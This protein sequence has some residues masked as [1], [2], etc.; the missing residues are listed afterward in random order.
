MLVTGATGYVG[1]H[2]VRALHAAGHRVRLLVR[3]PA[4]VARTLEPLGLPRLDCVSGDMTDEAAVLR[5][6]DGCDAVLHCAAV[7]STDPNRADEMLQANPLGARYVVGNAVRL[8]L[9]PVVYV[10]SIAA[11]M[12]PGLKR[13]HARLPLAQATTPYGRSKAAAERY[14]RALQARHAPVVIT[15]PG[16][17]YGPPAGDVLGEPASGI[18][19]QIRLGW[20]P[21]AE[22]SWSLIDARDLGR[23][24]AALMTPGGGPRRIMCGGRYLSMVEIARLYA[25]LL[26]RP[27]PVRGLP[28]SALRGVGMLFDAVARVIPMHTPLTHEAMVFLTQAPPTDDRAVADELHI[29]YR[30]P[31]ESL[32]EAILGLHR[33]GHL[34]AA[35]IGRLAASA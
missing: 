26:G 31:L 14:V 17:V 22:A 35:E 29:T 3:D 30:P 33:T 21:T 25:E 9:D 13:L 23:I 2:S 18:A 12:K 20:M 5:A 6:L 11:L 1:A 28:G 27:F 15:Y 10:S 34:S 16:S 32:R 4:K 24:H 19:A 8:G 7:V